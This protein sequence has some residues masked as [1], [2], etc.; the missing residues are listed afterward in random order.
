MYWA[1]TNGIVD[2]ELA[3][4]KLNGEY[5]YDTCYK[6][7]DGSTKRTDEVATGC[8]GYKTSKN[9]IQCEW[10]R[11]FA[12]LNPWCEH[13]SDTTC[14]SCKVGGKEYMRDGNAVNFARGCK[15]RTGVES[16]P[17]EPQDEHTQG[18]CHKVVTGNGAALAVLAILAK[19]WTKGDGTDECQ[20]TTHTVYDG[21]TCKV[22]ECG[23]EG[24]HHEWTLIAVH[25]PTA[26]PC[27]VTWD[28]INQQWDEHWIDT[29][30]RELCA[31]SHGSRHDCGCCG[32]EYSLEN[33]ESLYRK[34]TLIE[35]EIS[36]MWH[37]DKSFSV[38]AEHKA[39]TK[40]PEQYRSEH[41]IYKVL[42]QYVSCVLATCKTSLAE[43]ETR[44]HK[45]YQHC[46]EQH[47]YGIH[48]QWQICHRVCC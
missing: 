39:E 25:Q 42:E 20:Y 27:P 46:C 24:T 18:C 38:A 33:Q 23:T 10:E 21:W 40:Q 13:C 43:G 5:K 36:E 15:L 48:W 44:L 22:V 45:E 37:S 8:D 11:R 17:S 9:A 7:D 1:G 12:I 26:S 14:S 19:T 47:P 34:I 3:V 35:W 41:K 16:E 29:I 4:D 31:L 2:M 32:T 30:H 28:R 6:S